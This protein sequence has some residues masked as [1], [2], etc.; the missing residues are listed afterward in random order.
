MENQTIINDL[1][2]MKGMI[3][4]HDMAISTSKSAN[5]TDP[6]V[7]KLA[8]NMITAQEKEIEEMKALIE[9]LD[10]YK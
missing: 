3:P 7:K 5:I 2:Y 9:D 6:R 1:N 8:E 4:H 10:S